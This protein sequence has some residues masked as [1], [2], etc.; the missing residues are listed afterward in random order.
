M[1]TGRDGTGPTP[2]H[3]TELNGPERND[4]G[5]IITFPLPGGST[6][7]AGESTPADPL[8]PPTDFGVDQPFVVNSITSPGADLSLFTHHYSEPG[9]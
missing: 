1:E 5:E 3:G 2:V 8:P 6:T 7:P 4:G 9:T